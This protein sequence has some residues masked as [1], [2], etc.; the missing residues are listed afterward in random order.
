MLSSLNT[1]ID[2]FVCTDEDFKN[3]GDVLPDRFGDAYLFALRDEP[4]LN[5]D[6]EYKN[7]YAKQALYSSMSP[8]TVT[9]Q[10]YKDRKMNINQQLDKALNAMKTPTGST[11]LGGMPG[12]DL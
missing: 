12:K 1:E 9:G 7:Q 2:R 3:N 10:S 5:A 8:Y 4:F 6:F 11:I